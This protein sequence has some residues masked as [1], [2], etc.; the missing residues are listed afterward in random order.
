MGALSE[1]VDSKAIIIDRMLDSAV[2]AKLDI[3]PLFVQEWLPNCRGLGKKCTFPS[4]DSIPSLR[5]HHRNLQL[6]QI[7][8][9]HLGGLYIAQ[10]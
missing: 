1:S 10:P 9:P 8:I 4:S 5:R 3:L 6:L 7:T 2:S